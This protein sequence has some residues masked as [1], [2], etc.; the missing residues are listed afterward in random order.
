MRWED[1]IFAA[2]REFPESEDHEA[3]STK[4]HRYDHGPM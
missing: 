3:N 4:D 1:W 2:L